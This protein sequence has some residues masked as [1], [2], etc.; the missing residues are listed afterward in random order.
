MDEEKNNEQVVNTNT[1]VNAN[2]TANNNSEKKGFNITS[3]ILG[4]VSI[5]FLCI[6][7]VSLPCSIMAIIFSIAG[8]HNGGR[9]MGV[10]GLILGIIALVLLIVIIALGIIAASAGISFLNNFDFN[11]LSSSVYY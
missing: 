1:T 2:T 8:K 9:G 3:M 7:Y 6:W 4:I 5:L 11:T 10:A